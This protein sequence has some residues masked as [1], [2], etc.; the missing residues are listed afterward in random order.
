MDWDALAALPDWVRV[1]GHTVRHA[2]LTTQA[3]R[4]LIDARITLEDRLGRAVRT[5]AY[6]YGLVDGAV[7]RLVGAAGYELAYSTEPWRA[8]AAKRLLR[9]PRLEVRG[10]MGLAAFE[11]LVTPAT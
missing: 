3:L 6:P 11:R 1:G 9:V 4:E 8:A 2:A 7:Q 5:F 10:G